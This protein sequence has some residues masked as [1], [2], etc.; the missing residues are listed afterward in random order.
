MSALYKIGTLSLT[1]FRWSTTKT[2]AQSEKHFVNLATKVAFSSDM[3][4][5]SETAGSMSES[6]R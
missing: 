5:E 3:V 4:T 2:A 6:N 1:V